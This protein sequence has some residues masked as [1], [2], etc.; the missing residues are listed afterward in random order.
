MENGEKST[1]YHE[2]W[3]KEYSLLLRM[4]KNIQFTIKNGEKSTVYY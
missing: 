2:G 1:A 4:E 3:R